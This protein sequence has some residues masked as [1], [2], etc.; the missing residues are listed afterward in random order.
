MREMKTIV[1]Y[2]V[3]NK[4]YGE[5]KGRK[6]WMDFASSKVKACLVLLLNI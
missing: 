5:F 3:D 6:M 4:L 2:L 1:D